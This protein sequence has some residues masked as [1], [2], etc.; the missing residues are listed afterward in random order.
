M[1]DFIDRE[2]T[3]REE[4]EHSSFGV[5]RS[6]PANNRLKFAKSNY[7]HITFL[8]LRIVYDTITILRLWEPKF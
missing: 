5:G 6:C 2:F 3:Q 4:K 7:T 8:D 1:D